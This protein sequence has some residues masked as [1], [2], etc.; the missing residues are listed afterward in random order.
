MYNKHLKRRDFVKKTTTAA[1]AFTAVS[2]SRILGANDRIKVGIVGCSER[3]KTATLPYVLGLEKELNVEL[4][5]VC[6]IWNINRERGAKVVFKETG[7][8]PKEHKY[9]DEVLENK[10][11]SAIINSTGDFQHSPVMTRIVNAN[12]DC[13]TE[14]PMAT[15]LKDAKDAVKATQ[16]MKRIV[17]IG[18]SGLSSPSVYGLK[19]FIASGQLGKIS[20]VDCFQSYWGPRWRPR[21]DVEIIKEKDTDWKEWLGPVPNRPFDPQLYFEYRV[22]KDFSNGCAGQLMSHSVA[23]VA[24]A[25]GETFPFSV[26]ACGGNFVWKDGREIPDT[27]LVNVTYPSGWMW[28]YSNNF[29]NKYPGYKRYYGKNGTIEQKSGGYVASGIG[30]GLADTPANRA[31]VKKYADDRRYVAHEGLTGRDPL[32]NPNLLKDEIKIEPEGGTPGK[33]GHMRNWID[34]MRSRKQPNSHIL[35]GY[36]HSVACIMAHRSGYEGKN[37]YWDAVNEEIVDSPPNGQPG[38]TIAGSSW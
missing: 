32:I 4:A 27:F 15:T 17:Q 29:G 23:E 9:L 28:T 24:M 22:Y 7:R 31:K 21:G 18:N 14:K 38:V 20:K 25:M 35:T 34:C 13:F 30:G 3:A 11:I 26:K 10:D 1:V 36:Y 5:A 8:K 12:R 33:Y 2:Y 19:K 37:L 6:D 16:R